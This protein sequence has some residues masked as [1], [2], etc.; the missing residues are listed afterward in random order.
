MV[1]GFRARIQGPS[2]LRASGAR[3]HAFSHSP[4]LLEREM[5]NSLP[6]NQR[7][8]RTLHVQTDVLPYALYWLLCP[9]S[10]V[11]HAFPEAEHLRR[12]K[13]PPILRP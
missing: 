3:S 1:P 2:Q 4:P 13:P 11:R 7:R 8:H 10:A 6:N 12:P 5:G 9:V